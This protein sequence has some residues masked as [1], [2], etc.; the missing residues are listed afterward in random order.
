MQVQTPRPTRFL[1]A[2]LVV[3]TDKPA[4]VWQALVGSRAE[5]RAPAPY[6]LAGT[7]RNDG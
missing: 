1:G 7:A 2:L 5:V 3:F 4:L 6:D